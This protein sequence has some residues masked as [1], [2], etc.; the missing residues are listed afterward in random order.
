MHVPASHP[1][2]ACAS[3]PPRLC[4]RQSATTP[5][6]FPGPSNSH[7]DLFPPPLPKHVRLCASHCGLR[8]AGRGQAHRAVERNGCIEDAVVVRHHRH[9]AILRVVAV[10]QLQQHDLRAAA[11][12]TGVWRVGGFIGVGGQKVGRAGRW[13]VGRASR[14]RQGSWLSGAGGQSP[15]R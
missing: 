6:C 5:R 12:R 15:T 13:L 3:Q 14:Q 7:A 10:V 1:T 4:P 2:H 8:A 11:G 9:R